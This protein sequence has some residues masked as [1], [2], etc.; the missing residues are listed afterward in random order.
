MS[1]AKTLGLGPV[2]HYT[3]LTNDLY[4]PLVASIKA[5]SQG[6]SA[7]SGYFAHIN[8]MNQLFQNLSAK[9]NAAWSTITDDTIGMPSKLPCLTDFRI[10]A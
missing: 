8:N 9:G 4:D 7:T 5:A 10:P 2:A 3:E 1:G 6:G